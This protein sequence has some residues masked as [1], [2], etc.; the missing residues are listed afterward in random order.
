MKIAKYLYSMISI[1]FLFIGAQSAFAGY[2][3]Y[4]YTT[5]VM[6]ACCEQTVTQD[7]ENFGTELFWD[8]QEQLEI[9]FV[10]PEIDFID[11]LTSY[12]TFENPVTRVV[13]TNFFPNITINS[14]QFIIEASG[15]A[16]EFY[17]SWWLYLDITDS[18]FPN[19]MTR[20]ASFKTSGDF[21]YMR[22]NQDNF[23]YR[24][25]AGQYPP[26]WNMGCYE[27]VYDSYVEFAG[28]Y[29]GGNTEYPGG[30]YR[31]H[32]ERISVPEPFSPLLLLTGFAGIF[33]ARRM[34]FVK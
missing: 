28:Y 30:I 9:E 31:L 32:G 21:D 25:C 1:L 27:N 11:L 7:G 24:R 29:E 3:K 13:A 15:N 14:S 2:M 22:F 5:A 34:K 10:I 20:N 6:N 18:S 12:A 33:F 26:E 8:T 17:L 19:G 16:D 23:Y 4:T